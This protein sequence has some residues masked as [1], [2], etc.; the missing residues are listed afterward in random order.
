MAN[1]TARKGS[2]LRNNTPA[3]GVD[4][5]MVALKNLGFQS[6]DHTSYS[7][8]TPSEYFVFPNLKRRNWRKV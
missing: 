8:L 5:T 3:H 1:E 7:Y 6:I 4:K 2:F